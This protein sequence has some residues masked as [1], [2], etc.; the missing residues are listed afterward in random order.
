MSTPLIFNASSFVRGETCSYPFYTIR[1]DRPELIEEFRAWLAS[2]KIPCPEVVVPGVNC[3]EIGFLFPRQVV[4]DAPDVH[5]TLS[6]ALIDDVSGWFYTPPMTRVPPGIE[7]PPGCM[8]SIEEAFPR[9]VRMRGLTGKASDNLVNVETGEATVVHW[10][11]DK[12]TF[13][14]DRDVT[15]WFHWAL[16]PINTLLVSDSE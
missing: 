7:I 13:K 11:H 3:N 15:G 6:E 2:R 14:I 16:L 5:S 10:D 4:I 12:K 8:P 1:E 9:I